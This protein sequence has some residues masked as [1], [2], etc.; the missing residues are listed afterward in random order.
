[1][2]PTGQPNLITGGSFIVYSV[3]TKEIISNKV[4]KIMIPMI[5]GLIIEDLM[6]VG[7]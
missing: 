5:W 6:I 2:I 7:L 3:E 1:M 4:V